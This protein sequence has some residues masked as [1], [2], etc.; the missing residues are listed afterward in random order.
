MSWKEGKS[1]ESQGVWDWGGGSTVAVDPVIK[2]G[3]VLKVMLEQ[4]L[5]GAKEARKVALWRRVHQA[6]G[7]ASM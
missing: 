2:D 1:I 3:H 7:T 4:G 5:E 6:E